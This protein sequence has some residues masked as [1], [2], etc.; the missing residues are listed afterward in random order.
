MLKPRCRNNCIRKTHP[1]VHWTRKHGSWKPK[2]P[3]QDEQSAKNYIIKYKM[4]KYEAYMCPE[5]G[6]W[7]IGYKKD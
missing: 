6:K 3:F 1:R 7:H 4:S 2:H 5:C